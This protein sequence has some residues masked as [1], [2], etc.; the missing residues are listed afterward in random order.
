MMTE[1]HDRC[2]LWRLP[3][4]PSHERERYHTDHSDKDRRWDTSYGKD[5]R[6]SMGLEVEIWRRDHFWM[7]SCFSLLFFSSLDHGPVQMALARVFTTSQ[8]RWSFPVRQIRRKV[9][10]ERTDR[11]WDLWV[12]T[13]AYVGWL[14]HSLFPVSS[15]LSYWLWQPRRSAPKERYNVTATCDPRLGKRH[16]I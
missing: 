14:F 9:A 12:R 1:G 7:F 16:C 15:H 8:W 6:W 11:L 2:R 10:I 3:S 4:M 5:G 13:I